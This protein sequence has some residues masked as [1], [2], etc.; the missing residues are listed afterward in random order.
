MIKLDVAFLS[1]IAGTV[2]PLLVALVTKWNA[3]SG[4]K[5]VLNAVLALAAGEGAM[6][7]EHGG[8]V[9]KAAALAVAYAW[10]TSQSTHF[11]LW[12]PTGASSALNTL[13]PNLGF[14]PVKERIVYL[15]APTQQTAW[16]YVTTQPPTTSGTVVAPPP[17][18]PSTTE[19]VAEGGPVA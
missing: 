12:K 8:L 14:G 7:L 18:P 9:T 15:P 16:S 17:A 2:I 3:S 11:G 13:T 6:A 10:I 4:V 5:A 1:V 19:N